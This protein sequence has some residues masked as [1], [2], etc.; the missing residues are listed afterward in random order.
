MKVAETH[1]HVRHATSFMNNNQLLKKAFKQAPKGKHKAQIISCKIDYQKQ[2][3]IVEYEF[4]MY[5]NMSSWFRFDQTQRMQKFE[6]LLDVVYGHHDQVEPEE[7]IKDLDEAKPF[8]EIFVD[9][10]FVED[11][12]RLLDEPEKQEPEPEL[13]PQADGIDPYSYRSKVDRHRFR[14]M[15][16]DEE[17]IRYVQKA[18]GVKAKGRQVD[19]K[20][21]P[22]GKHMAFASCEYGD[23]FDFPTWQ[24]RDLRL[25][26]R[27][28]IS[29]R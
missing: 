9:G 6:K 28:E 12:L 23:E 25:K 21:N 26:E 13:S 8:L 17:E 1:Y 2:R 15:K 5:R 27:R 7:Y 4:E 19:E 16:T 11:V 10:R 3:I 14:N 29:E 18:I 24:I 20:G 22:T